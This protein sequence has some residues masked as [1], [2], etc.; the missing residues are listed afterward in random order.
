LITLIPVASLVEAPWANR[1]GRKADIASG[2]GWQV[3][4][5][6]LDLDAQFSDFSGYDRT[7]TLVDGPGFRLE[8]DGRKPVLVAPASAPVRFDGGW[9]TTGFILGSCRVLNAMTARS[10][11]AHSVVL[12]PPG[13]VTAGPGEIVIVVVLAGRVGEAGP[14]DA[15]RIE[16]SEMLAADAGARVAT[17]RIWPVSS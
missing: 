15:L 8:F 7:I 6:F 12:G 13:P 5:A 1:A 3:S 10:A 2:P 4:Y 17:V 16:G 14:L 11:L 9:L